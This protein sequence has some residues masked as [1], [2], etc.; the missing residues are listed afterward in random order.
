M[1]KLII[2]VIATAGVMFAGAASAQADLAQKNCGSC[3]ALDTKKMGPAFKDIAKKF[4]GNASAE[5]DLVAKVGGGKG[6]PAVKA[7]PE[8]L[9]AII[10]WVLAQ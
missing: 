5:A 8:D 1:K 7:S 9:N 10:K 4:K 3:H 6:H 2:A